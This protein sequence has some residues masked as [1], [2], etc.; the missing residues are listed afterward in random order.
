M[1]DYYQM[2]CDSVYVPNQHLFQGIAE[3]TQRDPFTT[4]SSI[5]NQLHLQCTP[6]T[7]RNRLR[8][9]GLRGRRPAVKQHL[10]EQHM[11]NRMAYA[12]EYCDKEV[13]FWENVVYCDEKTFSSAHHGASYVW[14]PINTRCVSMS[15]PALAWWSFILFPL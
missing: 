2:F 15:R 12:L 3:A 9:R 4:A 14:R 10:T 5:Q 8:E 13:S 7:I 1:T 11:E 6:E